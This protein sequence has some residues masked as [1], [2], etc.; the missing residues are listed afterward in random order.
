[1][2]YLNSYIKLNWLL[3][4]STLVLVLLWSDVLCFH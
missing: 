3:V 4:S 2:E 1:M